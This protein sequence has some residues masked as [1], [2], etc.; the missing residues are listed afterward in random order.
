MLRGVLVLAAAL[1]CFSQCAIAQSAGTNQPTVPGEEKAKVPEKSPEP[2]KDL[3]KQKTPLE[4]YAVPPGGTIV[5]VEELRAALAMFPEMFLLTPEAYQKLMDRLKALELQVANDRVLPSSCRLTGKLDGDFLAFSAEFGFA[6]VQPRAIVFLGLKGGHLVD[7]G[8]LDGEAPNLEYTDDGYVVRVEKSGTHRLALNFRV[9]APIKKTAGGS[10][11]RAAKLDMPGAAA[12]MLNLNLP[13]GVE[14]VV[15]NETPEKTKTPGQWEL[16][17]GAIKVLNLA[18]K[19]PAPIAGNTPLAKVDGQVIARVDDSSVM[20]AAELFLEDLRPFSKE[21]LLW[22]P[23]QAKIT[24][25]K[26]PDGETREWKNP[27]VGSAFYRI[28]EVSPG[29]WQVSIT[30]RMPRPNPGVKVP[31]GPYHVFGAFQ[32]AGTITVHMPAEVSFGQRLNFLGKSEQIKNTETDTVFHYVMPSVTEKAPKAPTF[33]KA[34]LELEWRNEKNQIETHVDH[35]LKIKTMAQGCEIEVSSRIKAASLFSPFNSLDLKLPTPTPRGAAVL[36]SLAPGL[37]FPGNLPWGGAWKTIGLPLSF[38]Q[39][40]E[41]NVSDENGSPLKLVPQDAVGKVRVIAERVPAKQMTVLVKHTFHVAAP[42]QRV[43][44]ELPRAVNTADR[45][46]TLTMETDESVELMHGQAGAEEPVPDRHRFDLAWDQAP[47]QV[48]LAWRPYQRDAIAK[49]TIDITLFEHSALV[50]QTL[51]FPRE[52]GTESAIDPKHQQVRLLVPPGVDKINVLAGGEITSRDSARQSAWLR[53]TPHDQEPMYIVLQ[54]DLALTK[55]LTAEAAD[56]TGRSLNVTPIWPAHI[57]SKDVKVRIWA[58]RTSTPRL[59]IEG[60]PGAWK[61]RSIELVANKSQFP[62]MVLQGFGTRLPLTLPIEEGNGSP[63]PAFVADRAL[64]EI[65]MGEDGS[66]YCRARYWLRKIQ[67]EMV[68]VAL[69][70]PWSQLRE[71]TFLLRNKVIIPEKD[72]DAKERVI[73]L[74]LHPDLAELPCVLEIGYVIPAEDLER[75]TTWRTVLNAPAF[76]SD[77]VIGQMRWQ[78]HTPSPILAVSFNRHART[79]WS[80]GLQS[81]LPTP[82]IATTSADFD[83]WLLGKESG[84]AP[85]S[86]TYA[87]SLLSAQPETVYHLP[88]PWWLLGCSGLFL[89]VTLGGYFSPMPRLAYWLMLLFIALIGLAAGALIPALMPPLLFALQPGFVLF[90]V[91]VVAHGL[92]QERY[93]RQLIF[94][95]GFV[96]PQTGS[97]MVRT[98]SSPKRPREA[99]TIDAPDANSEGNPDSAPELP[100]A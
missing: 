74:K 9:A 81:W 13:R 87:F 34:P 93:R 75:N 98:N 79:D 61:E 94:M 65:R 53:P 88:R 77:V 62:A 15:W 70:R 66:Q 84:Q 24:D 5:V 8:K 55:P 52:S 99:S 57:A 11:E 17:L 45:R 23:P 6:T 16:G 96:R 67:G 18:W 46:A 7:E 51:T 19:A 76:H 89:I 54:Y 43:R 32:H 49:A 85:E 12:T 33:F 72:K 29:K 82:E 40:E 27:G 20:I 14:E 60:L 50:T 26:G 38:T 41:V 1:S 4:K 44:L 22:L 91:F 37:G 25:V 3:P 36:G 56:T 97:T 59:P 35:A 95:P 42:L 2:A 73:R 90:V 28:P 78:M 68:E 31:I 64:I 30:Q 100:L 58:S 63:L 10:L 83:A 92:I 47:A 21:W 71:P 48:D 39:Y 69:P 86:V 80:W